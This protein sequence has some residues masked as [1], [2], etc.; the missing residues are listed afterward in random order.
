MHHTKRRHT[1][2]YGNAHAVQ[3]HGGS[4]ADHAEPVRY[5][6]HHSVAMEER[7]EIHHDEAMEERREIH[8]VTD[9]FAHASSGHR[10]HV[11]HGPFLRL[12]SA[13]HAVGLPQHV[14]AP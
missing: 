10:Q 6:I 2:H 11:V 4:D 1:N 7:C 13:L 8:H 9:D 5:G 12:P 14:A 3:V